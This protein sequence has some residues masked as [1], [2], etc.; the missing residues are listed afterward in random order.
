MITVDQI[1]RHIPQ[2][3]TYAQQ[4]EL[5]A[6]LSD[7]ENK[8][9]YT[10]LFA[11]ELLQGDGWTGVEILKFETGQRDKIKGI[12]LSNS[13]DIAPQ[14]KRDFP[15]RIVFA[16]L[17]ELSAL[18]AV[19]LKKID[20]KIVADKISAIRKQAVTSIFFLPKGADLN[21][22]HIALLDDLHTIPHPH[23]LSEA[24][25]KNLFTLGQMG[26]YLFLMKLSIHF[27]RFQEGVVRS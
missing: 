17:I 27:C 3:L 8:N 23:F 6:Q 25:R 24:S 18:E 7:F 5:A 4:K 11:D 26:F 14:N 9:Y 20:A 12:L 13:C 16:P 21:S 22:D 1:Q 19:L 10:Q 2:Y 15:P